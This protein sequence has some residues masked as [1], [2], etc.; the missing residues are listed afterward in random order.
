MEN[1]LYFRLQTTIGDD[2][3]KSQSA[4]FPASS[5]MGCY[6]SGDTSLKVHFKSI[7]LQDVAATRVIQQDTDR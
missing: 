1:Y 3:D 6:P 7:F 2:D 5:F 4:M